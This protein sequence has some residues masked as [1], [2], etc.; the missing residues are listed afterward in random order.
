L[1]LV[2]VAH[3]PDALIPVGIDEWLVVNVL[4]NVHPAADQRAEGIVK[5]RVVALS[6]RPLDRLDGQAMVNRDVAHVTKVT[7]FVGWLVG[8]GVETVGEG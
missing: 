1:V 8:R 4:R 6:A 2:I 7:Q 5:G 3:L